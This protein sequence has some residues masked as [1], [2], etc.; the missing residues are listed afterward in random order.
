MLCSFSES[1][2]WISLRARC[3]LAVD[4]LVCRAEVQ[5][6]ITFLI[7]AQAL[8]NLAVFR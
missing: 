2:W 4:D 3:V 5:M 8:C 7:G 1:R 6:S